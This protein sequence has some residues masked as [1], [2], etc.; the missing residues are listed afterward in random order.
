MLKITYRTDPE[1]IAAQLPPGFTVGKDPLVHIT[2]Y[3]YPVMNVPE[4]GATMT[5]AADF[6]GIEGEY[7]LGYAIDQEEAIYPSR[8]ALGTAQVPG[9]YRILPLDE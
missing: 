2:I 5:V 6:N 7:A 8:E 4:Y 3:N 1:A 9:R